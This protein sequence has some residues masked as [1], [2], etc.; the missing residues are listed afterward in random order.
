MALLEAP[1]SEKGSVLCWQEKMR[2]HP[3]ARSRR[4]KNRSSLQ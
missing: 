3:L 1:L 4:Q 2:N